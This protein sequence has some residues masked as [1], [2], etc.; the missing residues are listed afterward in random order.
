[1]CNKI[2]R[3]MSC[4]FLNQGFSIFVGYNQQ[5]RNYDPGDF[6]ISVKLS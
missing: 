1:M 4:F 6:V 5:L 2:I 3:M